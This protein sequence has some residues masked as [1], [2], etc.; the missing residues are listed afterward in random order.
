[1]EKTPI[2]PGDI[3]IERPISK[4]HFWKLRRFRERGSSEKCG[5]EYVNRANAEAAAC[6]IAKPKQADV[7]IVTNTGSKEQIFK[8][9]DGVKPNPFK[10]NF[11]A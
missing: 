7:Y 3:L 6:A 8:F 4:K 9:S 2:A 5:Y 10:I 1:M 11:E